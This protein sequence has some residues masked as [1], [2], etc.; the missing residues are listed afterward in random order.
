MNY[1]H[2]PRRTIRSCLVVCACLAIVSRVVPVVAQTSSADN[3]RQGLVDLQENRFE[4]ALEKLT[5]AE[6]AHPQDARIHNFLGITLTSLGRNQDAIAEYKT[7]IGLDAS[8]EDAYRNLGFLEWSG[9]QLDSAVEHLEKAVALSPDDSFAHQYLGRVYLEMQRYAQALEELNRGSGSPLPSDTEFMFHLASAYGA[10]NRLADAKKTLHEL[11]ARQLTDQQTAH[12]ASLLLKVRENTAAVGLLMK[13]DKPWAQFD[14]VIA[15]LLTRE[16]EKADLAAHKYLENQPSNPAPAWALIGVANARME[17]VEPS[18]AGFRKAADLAPANEENWL[19]LT[20][21]LM[22]VSRYPEAI[23]AVQEG[24]GANP[25]SY[26]LHLRLGAAYLSVNRYSEAEAA[27][28][29]LAAAGDPLPTSYVGLAQVLLRTNRA[30]EAVI[31]LTAAQQKLGPTFLLSYF[32]GLALQR[33]AK[34]A[35]ALAAFKEAQQLDPTSAE[36]QLGIG[37]TELKLGKFYDAIASLNGVLSKEPQNKQ[38]R[39]LLSAAYRRAGDI[40]NAT[41][42]AE[43]ESVEKAKP[44]KDLIGDF[45]LPD[46]QHPPK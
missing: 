8:L 2:K 7:A 39:R 5:V 36:A 37:E 46:W 3:F 41:K 15:Y 45:V 18:I 43:S 20:R 34:P 4:T 9:H 33:E 31:E 12:L 16:Y 10:T 29:E 26:A 24:L 28:R 40:Q 19:N 23:A 6:K 17:R 22:D 14:L 30:E 42:Y 44:E 1:L 25:K 32:R 35:E 21:E 38:A 11:T 13:S 27:F